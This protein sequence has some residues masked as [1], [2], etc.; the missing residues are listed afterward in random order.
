VAVEAGVS[1]QDQLNLMLTQAVVVAEVDIVVAVNQ[2]QQGIHL[3]LHQVREIPE[4]IIN[5]AILTLL[6]AV[7]VQE[8]TDQVGLVHKAGTEVQDLLILSAEPV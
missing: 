3:L 2:V 6:E 8:V 1:V 5:Q 4:E 7:G